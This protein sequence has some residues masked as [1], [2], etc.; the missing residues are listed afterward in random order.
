[1]EEEILIRPI[2]SIT[3]Q[4]KKIPNSTSQYFDEVLEVN[5]E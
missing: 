2:A 4:M 5:E 3:I 1:M